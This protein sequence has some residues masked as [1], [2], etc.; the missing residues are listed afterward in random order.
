MYQ[1]IIGSKRASLYPPQ[2]SCN[3]FCSTAGRP[4][5][6]ALHELSSVAGPKSGKG[7][8]F[9]SHTSGILIHIGLGS[10]DPDVIHPPERGNAIEHGVGQSFLKIVAPGRGDLFYLRTKKVVVP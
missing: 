4:E 2:R 7:S 10:T 8:D 9:D 6:Q 1:H 5:T 3:A